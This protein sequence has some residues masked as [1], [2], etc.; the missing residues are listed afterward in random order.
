MNGWSMAFAINEP[1]AIAP[2]QRGFKLFPES[3][4][5]P[6][7]EFTHGMIAAQRE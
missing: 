5:L 7:R 2:G 4:G 1:E 6:L 3:R